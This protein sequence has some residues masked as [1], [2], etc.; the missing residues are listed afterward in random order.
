MSTGC[1]KWNTA[2]I[3]SLLLFMAGLF[4]VFL[5]ERCF[6]C[7][8]RKSD[9]GWH[10]FHFSPC[11]MRK[12]VQKSQ[13]SGAASWMV[14]LTILY[15]MFVFSMSNFMKSSTVYV[16]SLC[17]FVRFETMI[18][19]NIRFDISLQNFKK[20]LDI[21][22]RKKT[23]RRIFSYKFGCRKKTLRDFLASSSSLKKANTGKLSWNIT[24]SLFKL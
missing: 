19:P 18:W 5:V 23:F 16:A 9:F 22:S 10:H 1:T 12:R 20:P 13:L 2:V 7:Q 24:L 6:A 3:K 11:L 4:I 14:S 15:L 21:F 17:T 8:S